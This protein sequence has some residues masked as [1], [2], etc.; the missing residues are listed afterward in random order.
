MCRVIVRDNGAHNSGVHTVAVY[1]LPV[2]WR[3]L[4]N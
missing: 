4:F 3:V 2:A 1:M